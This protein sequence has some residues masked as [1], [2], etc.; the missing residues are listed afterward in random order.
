MEL[1]LAILFIISKTLVLA[2]KLVFPV[3]QSDYTSAHV[4]ASLATLQ[5]N[6]NINCKSVFFSSPSG[7]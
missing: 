1:N 4:V 5:I 7:T 6:S 2:T 3:I